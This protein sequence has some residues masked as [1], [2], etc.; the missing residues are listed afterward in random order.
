MQDALLIE[1]LTEELPP[2]S[3]QTLATAFAEACS[4]AWSN[5]GFV[6]S[7]CRELREPSLRR[8]GSRCWSTACVS[9][10]PE[11]AV[12][13]KGPP[14][15]SG[16]NARA[17]RPRRSQGFAQDLRRGG[18]SALNECRGRQRASTSC[19]AH[20]SR[21][22]RWRS[23]CCASCRRRSRAA[24]PQADALGR[25]ATRS[26]CVPCTGW[27]CCMVRASCRARCWASQRQRDP[28]PS[29]PRQAVSSTI[30]RAQDY[31]EVLAEQG[32]VIVELRGRAG[33]RSP[34]RCN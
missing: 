14:S 22:S 19:S 13:R 12:E 25:R 9:E 5:E 30:P 23:T 4:R 3:L 7:Q 26:S 16:S 21:A 32:K 17:S 31:V 18:R 11:Q 33:A 1:L 24:H 28:R 34:K 6:D 8:A 2:K 10:Q 27:S 20:A 15:A 29:I